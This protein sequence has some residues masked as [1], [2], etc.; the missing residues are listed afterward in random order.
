M[1]GWY[2]MTSVKWLARIEAI[3]QPFEGPQQ[4]AY[5]YRQSMDDSGRLGRRRGGQVA[6]EPA[7]GRLSYVGQ[8]ED[9]LTVATTSASGRTASTVVTVHVVDVNEPPEPVGTMASWV[10]HSGTSITLIR[11]GIP[12]TMRRTRP[13]PWWPRPRP[14]SRR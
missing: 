3:E 14:R 4:Q 10:M 6:I 13:T 1:P 2:G 7:T 8:G 9:S 5:R 11:T 12:C